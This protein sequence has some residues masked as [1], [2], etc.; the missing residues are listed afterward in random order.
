MT[1]SAAAM[2]Q[3]TVTAVI[4]N[5][6]RADLLDAVLESLRDQNLPARIDLEVVVVDNGSTDESREV[7]RLHG[8][9][10][11]AL[12]R[13]RGVS[14]AFNRGIASNRGEWIALL[15]NDVVLAPD[16]LAQLLEAAERSAAWFATGKVLDAK[17]RDVI[18][19]AGDAVSLGGSAWR[20]G[21]GRPDG[22]VF[23]EG[24]ATCFPA[25]TASLFRRELFERTGPF[26][27]SFFAYLEDVDLGMRAAS[28][29]LQGLYVPCARAWHVG[30]A[31]GGRWSERSVMWITRHQ[32]KLLAKHYSE[33]MLLRHG[34]AVLSAQLG[35]AAMA[36]SRG[37]LGPWLRGF[38]L[39][40][41]DW[42]STWTAV[43]RDGEAAF[44]AALR[45]S[46]AEIAAFQ[47]ATGWDR[48][49][50]WYFA[51][52]GRATR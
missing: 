10:V 18:D 34:V 25:A 32:L 29:G 8:A 46:E 37:L 13:N 11:V 16:W 47:R 36:V 22:P 1:E 31:T 51:L 45:A 2:A 20:I 7:A 35:W 48:Y 30:S 49:W 24:R 27:E 41:L 6:N 44:V 43:P 17:R 5:R 42:T 12:E 50:R 23:D 3:R 9:R 19:G 39:G 28:L 26:D 21:H 52:A 14:Y 15:N 40:M 33:R 38:G 4:P